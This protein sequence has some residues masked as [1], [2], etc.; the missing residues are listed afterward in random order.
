MIIVSERID[1]RQLGRAH[2]R[3]DGI[4]YKVSAAIRAATL[5]F[6]CQVDI[7]LSWKML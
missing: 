2:W 4:L 7:L 6:R 5:M 3:T 1:L